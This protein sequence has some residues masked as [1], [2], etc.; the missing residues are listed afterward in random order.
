MSLL[1]I[2]SHL[3]GDTAGTRTVQDDTQPDKPQDLAH[4]IQAYQITQ[5]RDHREDAHNTNQNTEIVQPFGKPIHL[6]SCS[7]YQQC[8]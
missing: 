5:T 2:R 6:Q 7:S 1:N 8:K 4:L 3:G